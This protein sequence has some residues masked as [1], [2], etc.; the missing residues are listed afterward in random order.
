M[1]NPYNSQTFELEEGVPIVDPIT[2]MAKSDDSIE[3]D[4]NHYEDP[5]LG[6]KPSN[7][8]QLVTEVIAH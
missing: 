8:S 6:Y 5:T 1:P 3:Y 2:L 7:K 4:F